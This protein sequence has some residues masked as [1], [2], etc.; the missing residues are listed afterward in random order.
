[1]NE[2]LMAKEQTTYDR[3][4]EPTFVMY[5]HQPYTR[6]VALSNWDP[7]QQLISGNV[8]KF[9]QYQMRKPVIIQTPDE[10]FDIPEYRKIPMVENQPEGEEMVE[11]DIPVDAPEDITSEA[12]MENLYLEQ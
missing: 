6:D 9:Y 5:D 7:P 2:H 3:S 8:V 12:P 10:G 11:E 1:M 4:Y